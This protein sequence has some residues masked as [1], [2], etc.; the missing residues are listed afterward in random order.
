MLDNS[1]PND[2]ILNMT[3]LKALAEEKL[4]VAK[5]KMSLLIIWKMKKCCLP[6]FSLFQSCLKMGNVVKS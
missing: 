3:K 5:I 6:S 2:K 1:L 4:N